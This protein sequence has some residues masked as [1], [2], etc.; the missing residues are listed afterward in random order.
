MKDKQFSA[1]SNGQ[2]LGSVQ[3]QD[4]WEALA[5]MSGIPEDTLGNPLACRGT[6]IQVEDT[7]FAITVIDKI[8]DGLVV[9][10]AD[11]EG[12]QVPILEILFA[13]A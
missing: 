1:Y 10:L 6:A 3:A 5:I 4:A 7:I 13:I 8:D 9:G 2:L 11:D 12:N